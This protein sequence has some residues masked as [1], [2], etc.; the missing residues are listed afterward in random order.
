MGKCKKRI[1][2]LRSFAGKRLKPVRKVRAILRL[3]P[4]FHPHCY[5]I[6][7][8]TGKFLT[9]LHSRFNGQ[10]C[11]FREVIAHGFVVKNVFAKIRGDVFDYAFTHIQRERLYSAFHR[12]E[13]I[14]TREGHILQILKYEC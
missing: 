10:V 14:E 9:V 6:C 13:C 7:N 2:F 11:I 8:I 3:C 5:Y 4:F 12:L 1:V